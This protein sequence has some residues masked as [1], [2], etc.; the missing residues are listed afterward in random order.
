M[1]LDESAGPVGPERGM[2]SGEL[3]QQIRNAQALLDGTDEIPRSFFVGVKYDNGADYAF[4]HG[5]D[6][7]LDEKVYDLFLPLAVHCEQVAAAANTDTATVFEVLEE[8][9]GAE[10]FSRHMSAGD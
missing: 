2:K 9:L 6:A 10:S 7:A 8:L 1:E 3:R 5:P 4:A